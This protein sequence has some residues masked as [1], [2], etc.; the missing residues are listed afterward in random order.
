M[1]DA[2]ADVVQIRPQ[3]ANQHDLEQR[4]ADPSFELAKRLL[5]LKAASKEAQYHGQQQNNIAPLTRCKMDTNA[6]K[7]RRISIRL[8]CLGR[9]V[10]IGRGLID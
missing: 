8:R 7:G 1:T 3:N 2:R 10:G 4:A 6:G 5:R 9:L